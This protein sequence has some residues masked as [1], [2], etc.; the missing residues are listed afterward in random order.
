MVGE[1]YFSQNQTSNC[2]GVASGCTVN[3]STGFD[4]ASFLLGYARRKN[5]AMTVEETYM[6]RRPEWGVYVQDDFRVTPKL[7]LNMGVRWDVFVPW[8]EDDNRQSNFDPSTGRMV[9]ASDDAVI[10]GVHVGRKLQTYSKTEDIGPRLG[11]AYDLN[12][13]GAHHDPRRIRR[14]LELGRGRNVVFEGHEPA[15]PPG[16]RPPRQLGRDHLAAVH[17]LAPPARHRPH[18]APRA[19]RRA[20][21]STS[22]TATSTP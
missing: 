10:D 12:G 5:R 15:L 8:V 4:V 13:N 14:L 21:C 16:D 17:R 11:F 20:R 22:T 1:F 19:G 2:A 7:T 18:P 3:S 9:V 6:E